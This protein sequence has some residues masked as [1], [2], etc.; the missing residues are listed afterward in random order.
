MSAGRPLIQSLNGSTYRVTIRGDGPP[1]LLLHGFTGS[2][3]SWAEIMPQLTTRWQVV[4]PDLLGHGGSDA[5]VDPSRLGMQPQVADLIALL[6]L[7]QIPCAHVVGYSMGGRVALSL[8]IAAPDRVERLVLESASPGLADPAERA[9]RIAAD[10]ALADRIERDGLAAFVAYWEALALFASQ[11]ALPEA[12]RTRHRAQRLRGSPYGLAQSLRGLGTGRM[13][14]LWDQL[15]ALKV[16]TLLLAGDLDTKYAQIARQMAEQLPNA[17]LRIV[18]G[19]GHTIHLERQVDYVR[20][21]AD[22]LRE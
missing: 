5:P 22:F 9:A 17:Q 11:A 8:A 3:E 12:T 4:A 6:D 18:A 7:L 15:G 13:P 14:P 20:L 19:A 16:P 2:A 1:L 10:E 21:V